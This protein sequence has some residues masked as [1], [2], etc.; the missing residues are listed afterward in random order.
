MKEVQ[1]KVISIKI[2]NTDTVQKIKPEWKAPMLGITTS[3]GKHLS[4]IHHYNDWANMMGKTTL[5]TTHTLRGSQYASIDFAVVG[6]CKR[7]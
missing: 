2:L 7:G 5:I 3:A 1:A 6:K 4:H